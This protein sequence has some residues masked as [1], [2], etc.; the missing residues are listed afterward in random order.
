MILECLLDNGRLT[1]KVL[2][3]GGRCIEIDVWD[4]VPGFDEELDNQKGHIKRLGHRIAKDL[5]LTRKKD[6]PRSTSQKQD[7]SS[8]SSDDA[9]DGR[10]RAW[11][12]D[13]C[14]PR[15]LHGHTAT[16]EISFR[17]VCDTIGKYAFK[18]R[19]VLKRQ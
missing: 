15:V 19:Y 16:R 3:K 7:D 14:E 18:T 2:L 13:R 4:G 9:S 10:V 1:E 5:H 11:H 8:S 17:S 12:A 6:E